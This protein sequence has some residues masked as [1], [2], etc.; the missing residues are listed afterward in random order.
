[1]AGKS[2]TECLDGDCPAKNQAAEGCPLQPWTGTGKY[3]EEIQLNDVSNREGHA[4]V[5]DGSLPEME[6]DF[7]RKPAAQAGFGRRYH[8]VGRRFV[9]TAHL[10]A[11]EY[12]FKIELEDTI[13]N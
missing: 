12:K 3:I 13:R 8:F 2:K 11:V 9:R 10:I 7:D 5:P 1:M 4:A 6:A